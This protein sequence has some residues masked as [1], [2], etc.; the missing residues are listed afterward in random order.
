MLDWLTAFIQLF[1]EGL[2]K[3]PLAYL[4]VFIAL[5]LFLLFSKGRTV[6]Y[7]G[8]QETVKDGDIHM[9]TTQEGDGTSFP[10]KSKVI[11]LFGVHKRHKRFGMALS[12]PLI[13]IVGVILMLIALRIAGII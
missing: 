6:T 12:I 1:F 10:S 13:L 7:D 2:I 3:Y 5:V 11:G 9:F 8:K 4:I